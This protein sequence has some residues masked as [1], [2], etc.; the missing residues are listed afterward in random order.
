M[1][2]KQAKRPICMHVRK[3]INKSLLCQKNMW[4]R[5]SFF[6]RPFFAIYFAIV[7]CFHHF[8]ECGMV[9]PAAAVCCFVWCVF[10]SSTK[11][12][13]WPQSKSANVHRIQLGAAEIWLAIGI[14]L[15]P[16]FILYAWYWHIW[17]ENKTQ[18]HFV[19][20]AW[21]IR[22]TTTKKSYFIILPQRW[23]A[24]HVEFSSTVLQIRTLAV[25]VAVR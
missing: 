6:Y 16:E 12:T 25:C 18:R 11:A 17:I 21:L 1:N 24:Y 2:S 20:Q 15:P 22:R 14:L 10:F 9:A 13:M 8:I 19:Q 23:L 4:I 3:C 7:H 5:P